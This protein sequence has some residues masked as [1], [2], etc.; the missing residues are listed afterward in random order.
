MPDVTTGSASPTVARYLGPTHPL[1]PVAAAHCRAHSSG[2]SQAGY[3]GGVA[4]GRCWEL[5]IRDD[6]RVVVEFGLSREL[7]P[8]PDYVDQIAVDLACAG[9]PTPLTDTERR[10]AVAALRDRGLTTAGIA[11]RLRIGADAVY[12]AEAHQTKKAAA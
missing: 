2:R 9:E 12:A 4:C 6:E 8:D 3:I 11:R 1:A 5:A 7:T 10:A